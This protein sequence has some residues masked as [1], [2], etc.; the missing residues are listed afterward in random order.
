MAI[1]FE[2]VRPHWF[3]DQGK[4]VYIVKNPR[5][6]NR[7]NLTR[8][9]AHIIIQRLRPNRVSIRLS[10]HGKRKTRGFQA[11]IEFDVSIEEFRTMFGLKRERDDSDPA[12]VDLNI[13]EVGKEDVFLRIGRWL[14]IYRTPVYVYPGIQAKLEKFLEETPKPSVGP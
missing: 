13:A 10:L 7:V 11:E 14:I 2:G 12:Y 4:D 6:A 8:K 1:I 9:S 3:P 5:Q